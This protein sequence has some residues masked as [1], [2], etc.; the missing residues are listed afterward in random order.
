MGFTVF[1]FGEIALR[2]GGE[3]NA[4]GSA[5]PK[6]RGDDHFVFGKQGNDP[7]GVTVNVV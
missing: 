3:I 6:T 5:G 2:S 7:A 1:E 4:K